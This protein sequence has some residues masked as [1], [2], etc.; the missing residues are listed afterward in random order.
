MFKKIGDI[1]KDVRILLDM[2]QEDS[3]LEGFD[4]ADTLSIDEIIKAKIVEGV[5]IV[6]MNAPISMFD[7]KSVMP[8]FP[9]DKTSGKTTG[10]GDKPGGVFFQIQWEIGRTKNVGG[11]VML[12]SDY[13]RLASF[14]MNDWDYAVTEAIDENSDE[15]RMQKSR[16][17]VRGNCQRPVVAIVCGAMGNVLEFYSCKTSSATVEK[18]FYI[19]EPKIVAKEE[20]GE[21]TLPKMEGNG[22]DG[23]GTVEGIEMQPRLYDSCIYEI[24]RLVMVTLGDGDKANAIGGV[25][26]EFIAGEDS[27][28]AVSAE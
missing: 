28:V 4:D 18:A 12:P 21:A 11:S 6:E 27:Q 5:R 24:G 10:D 13:M 19:P 7:K 23:N 1:V 22:G 26:D 2:N 20:G 3:G 8:V 17:G 14:K 9:P 15:Y 16:F 25:A